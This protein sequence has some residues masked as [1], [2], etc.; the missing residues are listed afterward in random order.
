MIS[1]ITIEATTLAPPVH[2][3]NCSTSVSL[4]TVNVTHASVVEITISI[5]HAVAVLI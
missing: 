5:T 4:C 3:H 2:H 1:E